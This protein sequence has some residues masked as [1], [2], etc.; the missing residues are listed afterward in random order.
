MCSR[1][2]CPAANVRNCRGNE[3]RIGSATVNSPKSEPP[4]DHPGLATAALARPAKRVTPSQPGNA[5]R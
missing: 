5:L 1:F 2:S 4:A 3:G